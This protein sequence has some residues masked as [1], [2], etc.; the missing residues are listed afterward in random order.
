MRR[1]KSWKGG[2]RTHLVKTRNHA[3]GKL[4]R[5]ATYDCSPAFKRLGP[6]SPQKLFVRRDG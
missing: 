1:I 2:S 3:A 5:V 6:E 4:C